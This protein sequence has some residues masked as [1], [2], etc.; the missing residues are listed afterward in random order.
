MQSVRDVHPDADRFIV[1]A[2]SYRDFTGLDTAAELIFCDDLGF[3]LIANMK[4]WYVAKEFHAAIKPLVFRHMFD[5]LGFNEVVYIDPD[6]LLFMPMNEVFAG[7]AEHNV[8]LVP[9]MMQ[10]LQDGKEPSD[11]TVRK[12]GGYNLGFMGIRND[13]STRALID[14][15]A[16]RCYRY[17]QVDDAGNMFTDQRWMDLAPAFVPRPLILRH[18]GYNV[19]YW[20]FAHR[21]VRK[22]A[23]GTWLVDDGPLVFFHFS[24]VN[25]EDV[26]TLGEVADLCRLYHKRVLANGWLKYSRI[27]YGFAAFADG[28]PIEDAMRHWLL[29]AIDTGR[30]D[31]CAALTI[32]SRFF[33]QPDEV[34]AEKS[35]ALTRF[36]YQFWLDRQDLQQAFDIVTPHGYDGYFDWF[37]GGEARRQGVDGR[38]IAAARRLRGELNTL[39]AP[40]PE[41]TPPWPSVSHRSWRGASRDAWRFLEGDVVASIAGRQIRLPTQV[42]LIW[43]LRSDLRAHFKLRTVDEL[44]GFLGWAL[45]NGVVEG[46]VCCDELSL[47][48]LS[49][50]ARESSTSSYY[51][52]VPITTGLVAT[53][54]ADCAN[55]M[56]EPRHRF[57]AERAGRLAHGLWYA[58]VAARR[59][60]WPHALV[61]PLLSYFETP[62]SVALEG[63]PLPRLATAIW[64]LREDIQDTYP[65]D[66][67]A[68]IAGFVLWLINFGLQEFGISADQISA[69]LRHF[70][71]DDSPRYP[72]LNR[73]VEMLYATRGDLQ[74]LANIETEVGRDELRNWWRQA[75]VGAEPAA[76]ALLGRGDKPAK[77]HDRNYRAKLALSGQW[78]APTGRGE[79]IRCSATSLLAVGFT[80]FLI[81]DTEKHHVLRPDGKALPRGCTIQVDIN[82]LHLNADTAYADWRLMQRLNV[83]TNRSVGFW[84]WEL[85]RLPGYW[86]HAFSF[87]DEIW[88]STRFA[89]RAF[90]HE[91]LRPVR[92]MPMA[93]VTPVMERE[94]SRRELRLPNDATVFL[95]V[96]N[97]RSF[98][99]RKNPEAVVKAFL[100]A[101]P[102]C[103]ENVFLVVKSMGAE[104]NCSHLERLIALC[105]DPRISL[106]DIRLDRDE[107]LGLVKASDAFVSLH[108]SEGFGRGPAEA[109]LLGRPSILTAYSGPMD[110]V[111]H[112]TSF[113]VDYELVRVQPGEYIGVV[114]QCWADAN[115]ETAAGHM[116]T[117][118]NNPQEAR[119]IGELGR[120][121]VT[122]LL[123]PAVVGPKLHSALKELLLNAR[124]QSPRAR[125]RSDTAGK[126]PVP[127]RTRLGSTRKS[128]ERSA[129]ARSEIV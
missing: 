113:L 104:E 115:V 120:Q 92:L 50:M 83:L 103:D 47:D 56:Y 52:D 99:T 9:H 117:I 40:P 34:L 89:E 5:R 7:L 64:E 11:R 35:I 71:L 78:S 54:S 80:N 26:E 73:V 81:V 125:K 94:I 95:F 66:S 88:A 61:G 68:S 1:L 59:Y 44:I 42:A 67:D 36:M 10:P 62:S 74:E 93:V 41:V 21:R 112:E 127:P 27:R 79:D 46:V 53:R 51:Q 17:C 114:D 107:L 22:A 105:T 43:E 60:K 23:K 19:A 98:A 128:K 97:F 55:R 101:F 3:E 31:A 82:I 8:V 2:D 37:V 108:R 124:A 14:W 118:H 4:L 109:M 32:D 57:P 28:R 63:V 122:R 25:P 119:R 38:N 77:E 33:D 76:R 126:A 6:I 70:L 75:V 69:G 100:R 24:G 86:R 72:G 123:S 12:S 65:L 85:E 15:W 91:G 129:Q 39:V 116:R 45:T 48:F 18:P 16:S 90:R 106:R 13:P 58:Y 20:D 29:R 121:Q 96:F 84:A 110:F 111:S 49:E 87:F 30:I 102:S